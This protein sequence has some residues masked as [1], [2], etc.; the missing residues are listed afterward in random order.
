MYV[1]ML[2]CCLPV[3]PFTGP[4]LEAAELNIFVW[5]FCCC[6]KSFC[7]LVVSLGDSFLI[8]CFLLHYRWMK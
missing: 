6:L 7:G 4:P 5:Y 8:K 1:G 2:G 3:D